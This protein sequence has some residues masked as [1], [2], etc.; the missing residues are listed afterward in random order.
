MPDLIEDVKQAA[1]FPGGSLS[2]ERHAE[3]HFHLRDLMRTVLN[4]VGVLAAR[5][6][7]D[8]SGDL[9]GLSHHTEKSRHEHG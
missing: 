2:T 5:R 6:N 1:T 8:R 4:C 7:L 3:V 9:R